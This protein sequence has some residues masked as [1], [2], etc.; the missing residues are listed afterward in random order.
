LK[1]RRLLQSGKMAS[2]IGLG[3][4]SF[5]GSYGTTD[6]AQSHAT[7]GAALDLGIDLLDTANVYGM[8]ISEAV[9]GRF[10]RGDSS[11]FTI[12]TK[13]GI[14]R[15]KDHGNRGFNNTPDHLR[16]ELEGSLKRLGLDHVDLF[17]VHRRDRSLEIEDVMQTLMTLKAEGKIG[18]I[19]FSEISPASLRRAAAVGPVDVVQSEYSLWSR[20]PDLGMMQTCKDLGVA[21]VA[22]SPL[23]RGMVSSV[24]PQL[25][26]LLE[27][28]F[29]KTNPRFMEPNFSFNL[30][31][32]RA[33]KAYAQDHG[34]T[35][36]ALALAWCLA[37]AD[38]IIPIPGTRSPDHLAECAAASV[39][40]VT[41]AMM[42]EIESILPAGWAHGDRYSHAQWSGPEGYC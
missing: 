34:T 29:R 30:P 5:G 19:G 16:T 36:T 40:T 20:Q 21:L 12:A 37:R 35:A 15:D 31:Y 14:W 7:L 8:G 39:L 25:S 28:D 27:T 9:I 6:E 17:Y 13:A 18:G 4:M 23:A 2:E 26:A 10:L 42:A 33:F 32:A 22:Y 41:P 3:C 11:K 1:K 24:T 38:H